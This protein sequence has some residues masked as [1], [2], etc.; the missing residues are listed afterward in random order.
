MDVCRNF[1]R[2]NMIWILHPLDLELSTYNMDRH[3]SMHQWCAKAGL[4]GVRGIAQNYGVSIHLSRLAGKRRISLSHVKLT[5]SGKFL[6]IRRFLAGLMV[7]R[8]RG[9]FT[10][11]RASCTASS[12][13]RVDIRSQNSPT[14]LLLQKPWYLIFW[15]VFGSILTLRPVGI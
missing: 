15:V 13:V 1:Y 12:I 4:K 14:A 6:A 5:G 9:V 7:G 11:P 8:V 10:M 2:L 3:A